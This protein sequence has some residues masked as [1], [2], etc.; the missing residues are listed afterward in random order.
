MQRYFRR[1]REVPF[2]M[3]AFISIGGV[4]TQAPVGIA[5]AMSFFA[6]NFD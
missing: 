1:D 6:E 4:T 2:S 3:V 5:S